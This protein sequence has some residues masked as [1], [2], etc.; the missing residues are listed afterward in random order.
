MQGAGRAVP[1]HPGAGGLQHHA[2]PPGPHR[3]GGVWGRRRREFHAAQVRCL[4]W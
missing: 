4:H 3:R 1:H 2:P